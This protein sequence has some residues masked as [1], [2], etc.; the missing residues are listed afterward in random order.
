[1][2]FGGLLLAAVLLDDLADRIKLP[3]ILLV[4]ALGLLVNNDLRA[5]GEPLMSLARANNITQS[6]LILVLFFGGLTTNWSRMK[7]VIKPS[8]RLATIGVLLTAALLTLMGIGLIT[9]EGDWSAGMVPR[10]LFIGAM[11]SSTD[12]SA[13]ISLLR[14]LAGRMPQR[15]LDLIEMEST[16][17]DPMAVVLAG[18]ALAL[19]GGEGVA[20]ESLVTEVIRQFLLGGLLGFIGGSVISQLLM[21]STSL[22]RG[23]MLP[24]VSLALLLVLSGG[25]TLMGGSPLLAAYVAGLVLGNSNAADQEVLEDVHSSFAKMAELMLFLCLGLVVA[26]EDVVR[27]GVWA[28]LIFVAMQLVRLLMVQLLLLRSD[29]TL[30]ER[31]FICWTGLRGAVPIAMAIQ[32]WASPATWGVLMPPLALSVVLLGLVIQGFALV[33]IAHRLG[34]V[35]AASQ[36]DP[37]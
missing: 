5:D 1:M 27:A 11:F 18:L 4:L 21:G 9:R 26:P 23:S 28:L 10:V 35:Q 2:A 31:G 17:N 36:A 37:S 14:P 29:F 12:A 15:V 20:T 30:G 25:T 24:V 6:A 22:T 32:A 13:A 19:A 8:I 3:G 33:P 16:I 34:L 7:T